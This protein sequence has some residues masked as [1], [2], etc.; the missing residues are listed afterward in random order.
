MV[1]QGR[2]Y[3]SH[4]Q[5]LDQRLLRNKSGRVTHLICF[6][7]VCLLTLARLLRRRS[8]QV[9]ID[10][11][12]ELP[13]PFTSPIMPLPFCFTVNFEALFILDRMP[14]AS[15]HCVSVA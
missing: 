15:Q 14:D 2:I 5:D 6:S 13:S 7:S 4:A 1:R 8:L 3:A 10:T 12:S 11:L 9:S